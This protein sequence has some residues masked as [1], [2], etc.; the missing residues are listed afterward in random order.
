M[1]PRSFEMYTR[2]LRLAIS[3]LIPGLEKNFVGR[4]DQSFLPSGATVISAPSSPAIEG[5]EGALL[6]QRKCKSRRR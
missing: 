1:L 6:D 3:A 4:N 2:V 5:D